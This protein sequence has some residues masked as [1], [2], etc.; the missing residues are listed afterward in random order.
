MNPRHLISAVIGAAIL[1]LLGAVGYMIIEGWSFLDGMFM[2]VISLTTVGFGETRPLTPLG[3][4]YT[5]ILIM[6]G[7]GFILAMATQ[8][9]QTLIEGNIRRVLGRRKMDQQIKRLTGHY[10]ICGYGRIGQIVERILQEQGRETV[11]VE[12]STELTTRM[13]DQG[14]HYVLGEATDDD[15]LERAGIERA[16]GLLAA[17]NTDADNVYIV[18]TARGF[19]RDIFIMARAG[20][21]QAEKKLLRAG[22]DKVIAPYEIGA[23]RMAQSILRPTVT[24][25]MDAAM[26]DNRS[27]KVVMEELRVG[28]CA[29]LVGKPL[30]DSGIRADLNLIVVAIHQSDGK[31]MFNP[32]PNDVIN[33]GATLIVIGPTDKL[34]RLG[35]LL[36]SEAAPACKLP[37]DW[38]M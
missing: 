2:T 3:R 25:L 33:V 12:R 28:S 26:A 20:T 29:E 30:K 35:K 23:R 24:S 31:M 10:I 14:V 1:T 34:A 5:M 6:A 18:L 37:S 27:I 11:V 22:A 8:L 13:E 38:E 21:K 15:T 17:V 9:A 32:G 36:D 4:V 16:A 7:V 19:S